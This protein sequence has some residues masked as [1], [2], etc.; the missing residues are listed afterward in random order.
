MDNLRFIRE[1]MERASSFTAVSGWGLIAVGMTALLAAMLAAYQRNPVVWFAIW[2]GEAVVAFLIMAMSTVL[3]ARAVHV[4]LL[5]GVGR[6]FWLSFLPPM[7]VAA[8]LT[9]VLL[10]AGLLGI[11]PG[12]WLLLFGTGVVTGGAFSVDMVPM[13]GLCFMLLG[14]GALLCPPDWANWFMAA[15]FGGLHIIFGIGI[16]RRHGG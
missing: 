14:A 15:G 10:R 12:M 4:S 11:V 6:K 9:L 8:L 2:L 16:A 13:M 3:K 5:S 7:A 1:T